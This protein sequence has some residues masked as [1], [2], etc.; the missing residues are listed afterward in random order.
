M[1]LS[2]RVWLNTDGQ[3]NPSLF[4]YLCS[5]YYKLSHMYDSAVYKAEVEMMCRRAKSTGV[6]IVYC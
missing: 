1:Q 5:C 3:V 4:Q 2:C 6:T